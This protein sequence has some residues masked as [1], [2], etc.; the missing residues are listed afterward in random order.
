LLYATVPLFVAAGRLA[1]GDCLLALVFVSGVL[2][3]LK[4]AE[5]KKKQYVLFAGLLAGTSYWCKEVGICAIVILPVLLGR[6][7]HIKEACI[8]AGIGIFVALGYQ[9]YNYLVNPEAFFKIMALYNEHHLNRTRFDIVLRYLREPRLAQIPANFG[10]GYLLWFWFMIVYSMGKRDQLVSIT[11][12][13]FLMTVCAAS[14]DFFSYGWY[15]LPFYPFM[16]IAGGLFM[17]D[18]I[19]RPNTAKALLLLLVLMA[20]PLKEILPEKLQ[21]ASW[22]FRYCLAAGILPF[23]VCDFFRSRVTGTIAKVCGYVLIFFSIVINIYIVW[24]LPDVYDPLR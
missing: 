23:L 14:S 6:K 16:A 7:G 15:L 24:H 9:L 5:T 2:C 20:V 17:R 8:T 1:K 10:M 3:V 13:I 18:F 4:Y 19:F 12:F 11:V 21:G 22:L